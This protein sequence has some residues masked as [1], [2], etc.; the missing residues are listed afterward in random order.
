MAGGGERGKWRE[1][2]REER[3]DGIRVKK[4]EVGGN[5]K[6]QEGQEVV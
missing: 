2:R 4:E 6:R 3:L 1:E 5:W